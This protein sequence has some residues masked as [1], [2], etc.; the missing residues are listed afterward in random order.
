VLRLRR[1]RV[2]TPRPLTVEVDGERRPAWA[3][4]QLVGEVR[5]GDEVI[6]NVAALDLGLGSGGFDLVHA[7]LTRGLEAPSAGESHVM[8]LNYT[9]LQHPVDPVE[10]PLGEGSS[11]VGGRAAGRAIPVLVI[12]LHGHLAPAAWAACERRAG[13]R[14]GYVQSA[15]G[16][17]PGS[18]SRDVAELRRRGLLCGHITA[19]P[20]F[21]GEAEALSVAGAL[22]AA[23]GRLGWEAAIVG[24]GPG[25]L[26]SRTRLGHGGIVALDS[27]HAALALGMPA[28]VAPRLSSADPRPEHR[29]LSH[30]TATV[31]ELLLAPVR[32][33]VPEVEIEGWPLAD[34]EAPE[35]GGR[36]ATLD[37]LIAACADRH[38]LAVE[39]ID[40]AGYAASELPTRTM[41]RELAEDPLFFAA[42]LAG[43][44]AL[45]SI[46]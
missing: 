23:A 27:A 12:P 31:L 21:G 17:L 33:P 40:L 18:L 28:L 24:P 26:G 22:D 1:G 10:T 5:G 4:P 25:I 20:A 7:N 9:S 3:D 16:A 14:I 36:Q 34:S 13:T 45:G 41:G 46:L 39:G 35:G 11:R 8:K 32:V 6:V 43:G 44:G 30:H 15:G 38:D 29:G 19:T 42:A 37:A 2:V